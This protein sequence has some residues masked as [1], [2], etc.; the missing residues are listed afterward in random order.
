MFRVVSEKT[1]VPEGLSKPPGKLWAFLG[2]KSERGSKKDFWHWD[3]AVLPGVSRENQRTAREVAL[4]EG[5]P[6]T[7]R[8]SGI[9]P[10]SLGHFET[11]R[12]V[13]D[14]IRDSE[15]PSVHQNT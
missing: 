11:P 12:H 1:G 6:V 9:C 3:R 13:R 15:L 4:P 5:V 7:P 8:Y 14:H 10:K 2:L